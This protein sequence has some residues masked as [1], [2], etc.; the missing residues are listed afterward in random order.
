MAISLP[1]Q[2][3]VSPSTTKLHHALLT[4]LTPLTLTHTHLS[5]TQETSLHPLLS[6]ALGSIS[7]IYSLPITLSL[8][9][10][11]ET[12]FPSD[13]LP[14]LL[15]QTGMLLSG[16]DDHA[17]AILYIQAITGLVLIFQ[18]LSKHDDITTAGI[19]ERE[20]RLF[21]QNEQKKEALDKI[22]ESGLLSECFTKEAVVEFLVSA[23]ERQQQEEKEEQP[24]PERT[25]MEAVFTNEKADWDMGGR[26]YGNMGLPWGF[27]I[28]ALN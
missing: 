7:K 18:H 26:P 22:E 13:T 10:L 27:T 5:L 1:Q 16:L 23:I 12:I 9:T 14:I 8:Q 11:L 3:P 19:V 24:A 15:D 25:E 20:L 28:M 17:K 4:S 2:R 6:T 21:Q